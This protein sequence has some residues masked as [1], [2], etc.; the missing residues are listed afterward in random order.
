ML[1]AGRSYQHCGLV[2]KAH[3][4]FARCH[5]FNSQ[6]TS[7]IWGSDLHAFA[8]TLVVLIIPMCMTANQQYLGAIQDLIAVAGITLG[9]IHGY[10][11]V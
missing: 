3:V 6:V 7:L 1:H 2:V 8:I 5:G 9:A 4:A 10:I 11:I